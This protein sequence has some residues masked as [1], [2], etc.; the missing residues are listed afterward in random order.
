MRML[1]WHQRRSSCQVGLLG[2]ALGLRHDTMCSASFARLLYPRR[3]GGQAGCVASGLCVGCLVWAC[4]ADTRF[5]LP[6]WHRN[7]PICSRCLLVASLDRAPCSTHHTAPAVGIQPP[8]PAASRE[9]GLLGGRVRAHRRRF[10]G[11]LHAA[12]ERGVGGAG[13]A[14]AGAC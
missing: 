1:T 5:G 10:C 12:A 6:L 8:L 4:P 3:R 14:C 13:A 7:L 2:A 9:P 11:A